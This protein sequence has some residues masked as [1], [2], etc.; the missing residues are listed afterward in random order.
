MQW[1]GG[2]RRGRASPL[3]KRLPEDGGS[4]AALELTLGTAV[5]WRAGGVP[6]VAPWGGVG[7]AHTLLLLAFGKTQEGEA[8][9]AAHKRFLLL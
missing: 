2:R 4:R 6:E 1:V 8:G 3:P 7:P 5:A 9:L